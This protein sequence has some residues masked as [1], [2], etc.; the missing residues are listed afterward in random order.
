ML[1]LAAASDHVCSTEEIGNREL[2]NRGEI[3]KDVQISTRARLYIVY[4]GGPSLSVEMYPD[5]VPCSGALWRQVRGIN[6][7][8]EADDHICFVYL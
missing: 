7:G 5:E 1:F 4:S 8:A 6:G 2:L 3:T